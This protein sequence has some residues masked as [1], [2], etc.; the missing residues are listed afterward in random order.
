M[1]CTGAIANTKHFKDIDIMNVKNLGKSQWN[2]VHITGHIED[3]VL[4]K[5]HIED[6]WYITIYIEDFTL[7]YLIINKL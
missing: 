1:K 7:N 3:V 2:G 4:N 6:F 5:R